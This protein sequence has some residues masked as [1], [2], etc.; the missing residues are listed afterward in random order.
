MKWLK[1]LLLIIIVLPWP[2][3]IS[4]CIFHGVTNGWLSDGCFY[5]E[6]IS[7]IFVIPFVFGGAAL[8]VDLTG[9]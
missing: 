7:F 9:I 6:G 4:L 8:G 2:I 3:T 1:R 5:W